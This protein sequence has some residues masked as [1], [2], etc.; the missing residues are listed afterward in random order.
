VLAV[1]GAAHPAA[2]ALCLAGP[3]ASFSRLVSSLTHDL[4]AA[5]P[6]FAPPPLV[7]LPASTHTPAALRSACSVTSRS[8][9]G[10][11]TRARSC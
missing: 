5:V 1:S 7:L 8:T 4:A 3:A 6:C 10:T 11:V 9:K 2:V